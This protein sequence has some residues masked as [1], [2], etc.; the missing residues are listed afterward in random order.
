MVGT[1]FHSIVFNRALGLV[2]PREAKCLYLNAYYMKCG[3]PTYEQIVE[4]RVGEFLDNP[5]RPTESANSGEI[6]L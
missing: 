3:D 2:Q 4:Q 5:A 1:V 6:A